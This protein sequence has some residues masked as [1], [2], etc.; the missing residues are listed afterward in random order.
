MERQTESEILFNL[1]G[2][3]NSMSKQQPVTALGSVAT[4]LTCAALLFAGNGLL[5][6]LLPIRAGLEGY[7][8]ALIG[9]LGTAYFGG[10]AAGCFIGPRV[11]MS[12]GHVRAFAGLTAV[13]TVTFLAFPI[14]VDP[15]FWG[16]MRFVSGACLAVLYIVVESWL[17]DSSSN[18]NRGRILSTYIIVTNIVTMVGQL[19]VASSDTREPTL[20]IVAAMLICLSIVPLSLTPTMTPT[21]IPSARLNLLTLYKVSPVGV[22]GCLLAGVVEGA[23]WT[24]GPVFAQG[25]GMVT[26]DIAMLMAAFVFGGTLS[27]WPL[28]WVSDKIDRR[29]VIAVLSFGTVITGLIIGFGI[30]PSG[31]ATF[32]M[33]AVHG[34]LMIPIYALCISNA[35]D[36]VPK[37]RM[38]ETSGGLLLSYSIGATIGPLTASQFMGDDRPG[39]LF[40]FIGAILFLLGLFTLYRLII[41]TNRSR[42]EKSP[43]APTSA[44]SPSVFP[45]DVD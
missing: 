12:V 33:A 21:P 19:M 13:L 35:N 41:D 29:I 25:R 16:V 22:V 17:N 24:L 26:A 34:A 27:Q 36:N 20:F 42:V 32:A 6:T 30:I 1:S 9:L 3:F 37:S 7:S 39:G 40:V 23:F 18:A 44:A 8:I 28:G 11:I 5:Q 14:Y 2:M 15:V 45:M 31:S 10:F 4:I 43:F 38:V